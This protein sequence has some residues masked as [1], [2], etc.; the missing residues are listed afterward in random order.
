MS[1]TFATQPS[2]RALRVS[3]GADA[4]DALEGILLDVVQP[5]AAQ[6]LAQGS[7]D[8]WA[9][10]RPPAALLLGL[11]APA[12]EEPDKALEE[13]G[14]LV[15]QALAGRPGGQAAPCAWPA[16]AEPAAGHLAASTAVT[17]PLVGA[18]RSRP[19]RLQAATGLLLA[20]ARATGADRIGCAHWLRTYAGTLTTPAETTAARDAAEAE[21]HRNEAEWLRRYDRTAEEIASPAAG[22]G[23][24]HRR[25]AG[26]WTGLG[27]PHAAGPHASQDRQQAFRELAAATCRQLGLSPAEQA[28]AAWLLSLAVLGGPREP[29]FADGPAAPDR[30][31][32]EDSKYIG[33]RLPDQRPDLVQSETAGRWQPVRGQ[34][35]VA[36]PQPVAPGPQAPA[37]ADVLL[38]RRSGYGSYRG[39]VTLA[40]LSTLLHYSAAVTTEK[41]MGPGLSYA[42]RPYPSGGTRYP[43]QLLLYCHDVTGLARG[44]Y[45]YDPHAHAL[46]L[47]SDA[48]ISADLQRSAPA[49]DPRVTTPP[50]AGGNIDAADCPLWVFT[51]ADLTYQRLHYGLR[52]YR[53]VLQETGHLAQNLALV[54]TWLGKST[55]GLSG[56]YDDAVNQLLGV[57]GVDSAVLYL[58]VVGVTEGA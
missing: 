6:A 15:A 42:V 2:W 18:T 27:H 31:F 34:D 29:F 51:V 37:F 5:W 54:A 58:H 35:V 3:A 17:V 33:S 16:T 13:L 20:A 49:T 44:T 38:A 23:D 40:E 22:L 30:R 36:L 7:I 43:L 10:E 57:D 50:K 41:R 48:D 19:K 56:Y 9:L 47:L 24:W 53:L 1:T 55:V 4:A 21:F 39:P 12:G 32:H 28:Q 14:T 11:R 25:L 8:A 45:R 26:L 46:Q 52:S